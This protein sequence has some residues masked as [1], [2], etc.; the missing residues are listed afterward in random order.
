MNNLKHITFTGI[1]ENTD[2][3]RLVE[4]QKKYPIAEFGMLASAKWKENGN[5][6]PDPEITSYALSGKKLNLSLHLCGKL[7][8]QVAWGDWDE[9]CDLLHYNHFIFNRVQ[10][11]I[12]KRDDNPSYC[13]CPTYPPD[14]KQEIIIQSCGS[15]K[16]GLFEETYKQYGNMVSTLLDPS[17]GQGKDSMWDVVNKGYKVGY[18]GGIT[19]EN[20]GDK[21][22]YLLSNV[23]G[24]FW[25][26]MESGVRTDDW[27]DLDKV[28]KVLEICNEVIYRKLKYYIAFP[29]PSD[30]M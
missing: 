24:D 8:H 23:E 19:P 4:I 15:D 13:H 25:I 11:N 30:C 5:R 12:S 6:Y 9:V 17:G 26:D 21:L 28:E 29:S 2:I 22:D 7:A 14:V 10:L 18:A 27:F 3:S 20:V 16:I 1:D